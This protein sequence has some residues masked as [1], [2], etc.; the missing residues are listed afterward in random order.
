MTRW[1]YAAYPSSSRLWRSSKYVGFPLAHLLLCGFVADEFVSQDFEAYVTKTEPWGMRSGITKII[2]PPE[3]VGSLPAMDRRTLSNVQIRNPIQQNMM[4][5]GGVFRQ[6]NI[7]KNKSRPLSVR[8]WFE[9]CGQDKFAGPMPREIER[10]SK[11]A[12]EMRAEMEREKKAAKEKKLAERERRRMQRLKDEE[13]RAAAEAQAQTHGQVEENPSADVEMGTAPDGDGMQD[14]AEADVAASSDIVPALDPS[15][16]GSSHSSPDPIAT[17]PEPEQLDP[18][19]VDT[20]LSSAWLP[21]NTRPEDYTPE[22]CARLQDKFWKNMGLG[23]PSWYGADL[24]QGESE[25][26]SARLAVPRLTRRRVVVC[27]QEDP[28]ERRQPA[29]PPEPDRDRRAGSE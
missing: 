22:A 10:G 27:R 21:K 20:D 19:Y 14:E 16:S 29:E 18:W 7:E 17:T 25:L 1:L 9:K 13:A 5:N 24:M 8:E 12:R 23:E 26:H 3:W 28:L 15:S 2:P 4:G 11:E 6:T